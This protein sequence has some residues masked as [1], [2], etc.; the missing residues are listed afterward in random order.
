MRPARRRRGWPTPHKKRSSLCEKVPR[1]STAYRSLPMNRS[2]VRRSQFHALP[3][4]MSPTIQP[5]SPDQN[6]LDQQRLLV[7]EFITVR[8][9]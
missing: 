8:G 2:P 9:W 5:R 3:L 7:D 4:R 6:V 1:I